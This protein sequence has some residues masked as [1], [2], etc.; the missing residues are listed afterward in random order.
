MPI[1]LL[2]RTS[3]TETHDF[4][5]VMKDAAPAVPGDQVRGVTVR[6]AFE[7]L[8]DLT[9]IHAAFWENPM[10]GKLDW[11]NRLH[12][13]EGCRPEVV[14]QC[15][16][17]FLKRFSPSL[18]KEQLKLG[19][20]FVRK[21]HHW[22]A[23]Y[24]GTTTLVHLDFRPDNFMINDDGTLNAI[25]DWQLVGEHCGAIDAAFLIGGALE[26]S[27]RRRHEA[28]LVN[29]YYKMLL[30][31][32]VKNYSWDECWRDYR[33]A[34]LYGVNLVIVASVR[35]METERGDR[36]FTDMALRHFAQALDLDSVGLL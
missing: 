25:V 30:S 24:Q 6:E 15:W 9:K 34:C 36:M 31:L 1:L 23:P 13:F 14:G 29:H 21:I 22:C 5:L 17:I 35:V 20:Q 28:D 32:G 18:N 12:E 16:D 33:R 7:Y 27:E 3:D 19:E 26:L 10:L 11:L 4:C 8:K 2:T